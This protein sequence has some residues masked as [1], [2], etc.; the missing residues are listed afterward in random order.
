[1]LLA[2][3]NGFAVKFPITAKNYAQSG[4]VAMWDGVENVGW[5]RHEENP[6]VWKNLVEGSA[7]SDFLIS[8]GKK[9]GKDHLIVDGKGTAESV[10]AW[11]DA[12]TVM[13]VVYRF[14]TGYAFLCTNVRRKIWWGEQFGGST[15]PYPQFS[16]MGVSGQNIFSYPEFAYGRHNGLSVFYVSSG[17]SGAY[18]IGMNGELRG[19]TGTGSQN[20]TAPSKTS[21]G[22]RNGVSSS[23]NSATGIVNC[24]RLYNRELSAREVMS[25]Y[26][27]DK[28]R[29]N[30]P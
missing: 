20:T 4:L 17:N 25:N 23:Y 7:F 11:P 22:G 9:F 15:Y 26:A 6:S 1:M 10:A 24:I 3:R 28:I 5:G 8:G 14:D 21:I 29:F 19:P 12:F 13:E 27:I 18:R 30:L 2:S 16:G